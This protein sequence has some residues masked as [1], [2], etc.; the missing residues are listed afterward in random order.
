MEQ[1]R[2][3][4]VIE[5]CERKMK[6]AEVKI[7]NSLITCLLIRLLYISLILISIEHKL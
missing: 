3:A 7:T 4:E 1:K 2:L 6:Q 5:E